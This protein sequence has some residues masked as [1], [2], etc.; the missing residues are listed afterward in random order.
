MGLLSKFYLPVIFPPSKEQGA[1]SAYY[2]GIES[3]GTQ[4]T[5]DSP[6]SDGALEITITNS[7]QVHPGNQFDPPLPFFTVFAPTSG[8]ARF[9]PGSAVLPTPNQVEIDPP[10]GVSVADIGS[11]LI[12]VWISDFA[13]FIETPSADPPPANRILVSWL[14]PLTVRAAFAAEIKKYK[15]NVL[16]ESWE[17]AGGTETLPDRDGLEEAFLER[18]MTGDAEIF[19]EAG[20]VI[21]SAVSTPSNDAKAKI[22]AYFESTDPVV[23]VFTEVDDLIEK[24]SAQPDYENHPV[25]KAANGDQHITFNSKFTVWDRQQRKYVPFAQKAVKLMKGSGIEVDYQTT[26][27]NGE[28]VGLQATLKKR[29]LIYFEYSTMNETI[30]GRL[31]EED[32]KT[33]SHPAGKYVKDNVNQQTY[34]AHYSFYD[35]YAAFIDALSAN[36][37]T[38]QFEEDRGNADKGE[39][40]KKSKHKV[41]P[42]NNQHQFLEEIKKSENLYR[43]GI[44]PEKMFV[45][46]YEGDSWFNYPL[47]YGDIYGHLHKQKLSNSQTFK[48]KGITYLSFPLQHYGD[49]S[50]QMFESG[51]GK[52]WNHLKDLLSEFKIDLIVCSSG[53]NDI[54]EPGVSNSNTYLSH[55]R[56]FTNQH[57]DPWKAQTDPIELDQVQKD[58]LLRQVGKS[59]AVLLQNHRWSLYLDGKPEVAQLSEGDMTPTLQAKL[60]DLATEMGKDKNTWLGGSG[61]VSQ[62]IGRRVSQHVPGKVT[63]DSVTGIETPGKTTL[64]GSVGDSH[65]QLLAAVFHVGR[66]QARLLSVKNNWTTFLAHVQSLGIPVIAHSYCYPFFSEKATSALGEGNLRFTGPWFAPRFK[67]ANIIDRRVK[68]ICLKT[69]VDNYVGYVLEPLK[70]S[71]DNFHYVDVREENQADARWRDEMH[72]KNDGFEVVAEK[73]YAVILTL[74]NYKEIVK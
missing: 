60:D 26:N 56:F 18:F 53:G 49:R 64:P 4:V 66:Y 11:V 10:L 59:F 9:Y 41:L 44:T 15:D 28:F 40:S 45:V 48:D 52:Q 13:D 57:F 5:L 71:F 42:G 47:A 51:P 14:D 7:H 69:I 6:G 30:G 25:P 27:T 68:D 21:G 50:D 46:L 73:I 31:F 70:T 62:E 3:M 29:E 32:I 61:A 35:H 33:E 20:T 16:Q 38:E 2:A 55:D 54:A 19:V 43:S 36:A 1:P 17:N 63:T 58:N 34:K 24:A 65:D 72:L 67:E 23:S 12:R 74:D 37:D 39:N 8:S 22:Q